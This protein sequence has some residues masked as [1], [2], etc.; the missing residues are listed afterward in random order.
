[1]ISKIYL[2]RF[3][4]IKYILIFNN[5]VKIFFSIEVDPVSALVV[6]QNI[7]PKLIFSNMQNAYSLYHMAKSFKE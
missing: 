5:I 4:Y 3:T 7:A 1:V 2:Q 6:Q